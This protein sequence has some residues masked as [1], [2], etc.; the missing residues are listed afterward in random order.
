MIELY[1]KSVYIAGF[2]IRRKEILNLITNQFDGSMLNQIYYM[3]EVVLKSPSAYL[4][5][6]F[7]QQYKSHEHNKKDVMYDRKNKVFVKRE[8]TLAISI[9]FLKSF[10]TIS[11]YIDN[12]Y[13]LNCSNLIKK[14]CL[15]I[16]TLHY[17]FIGEK[18]L[19]FS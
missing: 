5:I 13:S 2:M 16:Y 14:I 1:R 15:S 8:P 3:S 7:T 11:S 6:P 4:D 9:K 19:E 10:H 12:K 17:Q 18:D